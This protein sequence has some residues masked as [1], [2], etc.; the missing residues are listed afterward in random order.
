MRG[1]RWL[2]VLALAGCATRTWYN[3]ASEASVD[4][5]R[6]FLDGLRGASGK[7]NLA[8]GDRCYV[9]RAD[10]LQPEIRA[11]TSA[12]ADA[13]VANGIESPAG[14][15]VATDSAPVVAG[16]YVD[17]WLSVDGGQVVVKAI[18]T[19]RGTQYWVERNSHAT[20]VVFAEVA[21]TP[22]SDHAWRRLVDAAAARAAGTNYLFLGVWDAPSIEIDVRGIGGPLP[23]VDGG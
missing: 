12:V 20:H 17:R 11:F 8:A 19:D 6:A 1:M 7:A 22:A 15:Y 10:T 5:R 13:I 18:R 14:D 21:G 2:V 16:S 4:E 3:Y 23:Q 9:I